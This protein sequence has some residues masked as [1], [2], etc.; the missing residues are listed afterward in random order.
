[1]KLRN[2]ISL[3]IGLILI[4]AATLFVI[5]T[6]R[7]QEDALLRGIDTELKATAT[8]AREILPADY[9]DRISGA[10]SVSEADYMRIVER[11]DRLCRQ[12]GLEYIWSL[13][14]IDGKTVF[15][16][17]SSTSK[18]VN[19]G[20]YA[21]F[22]ETHSNPELYA[23]AFAT[24]KPQYQIN[25]DK[26]GRIRVVLI[27]FKDARGRPYL[28]GASIK[29]TQVD[30]LMTK[31]DEQLLVMCAIIFP[32]GLLLSL[33]LSASLVRPLEKLTELARNITKG[34]WGSVVESSGA[35]EI[36]LLSQCVNA[37]SLS[38]QEK[39][40]ECRHVENELR[41]S[42]SRFRAIFE[43]SPIAIWE[44]DFSSVKLCFD[45]LARSGVADFR[46]Y[47]DQNPDEL[48]NLAAGVR[49]CEVN[50]RSLELVGVD[51][52]E[53]LIRELP[54]YFT[55]AS[56][57]VFKEEMIALAEGN[58]A[59]HAEIPVVNS[60]GEQRLLDLF[61]SVP[62]EH[63][64]DLSRVLVSFMDITDRKLA[65]NELREITER[66]SIAFNFAP[67]MMSISNLQDGTYQDVNQKYLDISGF[68]RGDV[69]GKTSIE[70]GWISESD[71]NHLKEHMLRDG[72]V[73][74]LDL[75]LKT[76][77]G[78]AILC[79]YWGEIITVAGEKRLLSIALD[80]TAHRKI[81]QQLLQAQKMESVG[82]LAG[83][84]AHDFNNMLSVILGYASL[85]LMES[86]LTQPLRTKLE[87]IRKAAERSADLT[88]QLLAFSRQQTIVPKVLD[89]NG[90]VSGMF[91]M[92]QRLIG[93]DTHITW[94]PAD[95]LWPVKMDPSQIDQIL[96]NLCVNA[97]DSIAN[98]GKI[99]I[100]T[101]N[102]LIDEEYCAHHAGFVIGD[103]VRLVVSDDGCG[104]DKETLAQIFEP[105][106]TTK[107]IGKGT[108]LGLAT[109]Y[110]IIKQNNG[111]INVYSE[112]G[113]GTT[114]TIYL[115]RHVAK[116]TE[117]ELTIITT[118]QTIR[119]H[120]TIL[121]VEDE[122]AILNMATMILT[123]QGYTVLPANTPEQAISL[124]KEST[125][126]INLLMT[127]VVMPGMNGR[128]LAKNLQTDYP[129]LKTL[130]M[131]GY[132]ANVIAHH[133]V[134]DAG[135]H[136]IQKPFSLPD[137]ASKVREVL[138]ETT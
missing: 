19:R 45:E 106:F 129:Q 134:L 86:D 89:L 91:K 66:F 26:W 136:F 46:S 21:R 107:E 49:I 110:G 78:Q 20:D 84:V 38:I 128:D 115:P 28:F 103:Y 8:L 7:V 29:M 135:V 1:M 67:I 90:T 74:G 117:Q 53:E 88:R 99:T 104:M 61:L 130:F 132:T 52:A 18:D 14:L 40:D 92:L 100:E 5:V 36:K 12:M 102:S 57:Q 71:R 121:L 60:K 137:L 77:S 27:P 133:G 35:T 11:W 42:E 23:S 65:E 114:F 85:A 4:V 51:S 64:H 131:S 75:N 56:Y 69:I 123:R 95:K 13:M 3:V 41:E 24:M 94:H 127:D 31:T 34:N 113:I 37:M 76:K 55:D 111:F 118:E 93:E 16:S 72:K 68:S 81:E 96:V 82:R 33:L 6:H 124:A 125:G 62:P 50:K 101:G 63:T 48:L 109:I 30:A 80:I 112:P 79:K 105:F 22:F 70:L 54:H 97:R 15:T 138:D 116:K 43:E 9:H 83:G 47:L 58:R 39:I 10:D 59:F 73:H 122:S 44:E 87:E 2:Q 119:G 25:N 108:G 126:G 17:G 120:E 32:L 98:V